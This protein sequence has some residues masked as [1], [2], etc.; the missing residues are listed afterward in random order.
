MFRFL[1]ACTSLA[2]TV[3][4]LLEQFSQDQR[5]Y[6]KSKRQRKRREKEQGGDEESE[7][8]ENKALSKTVAEKSFQFAA[9]EIVNSS[10][11]S[12]NVQKF[13]NDR[14][15]NTFRSLLDFYVELRP[16]QIKRVLVYFH[17][18]FVKRKQQVILYRLDI[19][20]LLARMINDEISVPRQTSIRKHLEDFVNHYINCLTRALIKTPAL[21]IEVLFS[22]SHTN[23]AA[24]VFQDTSTAILPT[25]WRR[26][27]ETPAETTTCCRRT[28]GASWEK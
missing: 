2:H 17:R 28:G 13:A 22:H 7:T 3:L 14:C 26:R 11:C 15:I 27:D 9:F 1:D 21:F 19:C 6:V 4:K 8:E 5:L 18:I 10:D 23:C 24:V 25:T 16:D 20:E 12:S